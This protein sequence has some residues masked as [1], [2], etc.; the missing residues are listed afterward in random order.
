[1]VPGTGGLIV[2]VSVFALS[3]VIAYLLTPYESITFEPRGEGSFEP[4]L[5]NYTRAAETLI[6]LASGSVVLLA[7]SSILRAGG[8]L[9]WFY[10]S[11]LVLLGVNVIYGVVFIGLL[12]VF[13]EGFLHFP[14]SYT[15]L[16]Y[17]LVQAFGFAGLVCFSLAYLWLAFTLGNQ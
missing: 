14:N 7:G 1:L 12:I 10:A 3:W 6:S 2:G 13:Y 8:H 4:R 15:R 9:P 16:R 5:T 17:S 11:P